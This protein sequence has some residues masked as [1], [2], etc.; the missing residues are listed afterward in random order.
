MGLVSFVYIYTV[1]DFRITESVWINR[2]DGKQQ[3][4]KMTHYP[5]CVFWFPGPSTQ[6]R[7]A[8]KNPR[9]CRC[10]ARAV[11]REI[12]EV[13]GLYSTEPQTGSFF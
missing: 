3:R 2:L 5:P 12:C 7:S 6:K 8:V 11:G 13:N 1:T 10:V 4:E 9:I